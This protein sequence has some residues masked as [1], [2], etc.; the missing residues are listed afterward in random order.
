ML[1]I[2]AC[3]EEAPIEAEAGPTVGDSAAETGDSPGDS[4]GSDP[5]LPTLLALPF[6]SVGEPAP[7]LPTPLSGE[8]EGP[9]TLEDGLLTLSADLDHPDLHEGVLR[10][11]DGD[12]ALYA[13]VGSPDLPEPSWQSDDWGRWALAP[14][15]TAP[16]PYGASG[17]DDPSVLVRLPPGWDGEAELGTVLH[18]HGHNATVLET[19]AE[20]FLQEQLALSGR[21]AVLVM[22]QGPEE[23]ADSDFGR[24]ETEDGAWALLRDVLSL[25]YRDG[26]SA[27]A[28]LGTVVLTS[29][30]GGYQATASILQRGGVEVG[31][32][33]LFDSLYGYE[34]VYQDYAASGRLLSVY[35]SSGGTD[36][37]N[38]SLRA[39]L[40]DEGQA[41]ARS[42]DDATLF[43][44]AR[45]IGPTEASH[46]GCLYED[47]AWAR[48]LRASGLPGAPGAPPELLAAVADGDE[49]RVSWRGDG[50][51][52]VVEISDDGESWSEAASTRGD[53]ARV[54]LSGWI[55]VHAGGE[56]SD[57]YGATGGDWWIVDGFD[58][59]LDGSWG[60]PTHDFVAQVLADA[61]L[62]ASSAS[63]E[64]V[65][66]GEVELAGAEG[67]IWLLGDEG[68]TDHVFTDLEM[69]RIAAYV[70]GG[71]RFVASG[72]EIGY[73]ADGDWLE[74]V[75]LADHLSDDAGT[76]RVEDFT[77]G[78]AYPEDYPD[79]LS[80]ERTLWR[81]DSGG[82]A[83]VVGEG[84]IAVVGFGIENIEASARAAALAELIAAVGGP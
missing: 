59:V 37:N 55:R 11:A 62:A 75:L 71:G 84:R 79:V 46:G 83:A 34:S 8:V 7:S 26:L 56:P 61:G 69:E 57:A 20:Q 23:A 12:V 19:A 6:V 35:T 22:P 76:D 40:E 33:H 21:N 82:A 43:G 28:E 3:E 48:W 42:F 17:Y 58:R 13:V 81:Y 53:S 16:Y 80:G 65:E 67:V 44:A 10:T 15:A 64:A 66:G 72:A 24:L 70:D 1:W 27:R 41:V 74:E 49:A 45:I 31:A 25:L 54:P 47:R 68:T 60:A 30:S 78:A 39:D 50:L 4:A 5:A 32:V 14:F 73:G 52:Y 2:A 38:A 77:I 51:D 36:D 29:H 18:L 63:N 9:F